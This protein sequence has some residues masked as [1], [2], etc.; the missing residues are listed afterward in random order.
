MSGKR[1]IRFGGGQ[2]RQS[3]AKS[4]D[5]SLRPRKSSFSQT[6]LIVTKT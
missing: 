6:A 5:R 4:S 1:W 2:T 3:A